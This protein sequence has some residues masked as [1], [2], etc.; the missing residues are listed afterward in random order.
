MMWVLVAPDKF[1]GSLSAGAVAES[2]SAG[3]ELAGIEA[4]QLPLADGGDGSVAAASAAGFTSV[5]I[6]VAGATGPPQR[7][8]IAIQ[9]RTA[10][11]EIANT[12]GL[13]TLRRGAAA[14]L[15]ASSLGLGQ[16]I[17]NAL[18]HQ[19]NTLI[20]ALGGSASTDGGTGM[21]EALGMEF[22]DHTGRPLR[23]SG[24]TLPMIERIDISRSISLSGI[25]IVVASDVTNPLTGSSGAAEIYGPQKGTSNADVRYLDRGLVNLVDTFARCGF[26]RAP[27]I[28]RIPGSG[29]A[30]GVGFAAALLGARIGSGAQYFLDLLDFDTHLRQA[31]LVVTG[32]G[33]IDDQTQSG[34]L[35]SV[36]IARSRPT[37]VIAAAGRCKL[38]QTAWQAAG[39]TAVH[40]LAD[41]TRRCTI[42]DPELTRETLTAIGEHIGCQ[43]AHH[44]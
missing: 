15:D 22:L 10:V 30:G 1:K 9:N 5:P 41:F 20:L 6:T 38:N 40:T 17:K 32:E 26:P 8:H 19:P 35:L 24:R 2:L 29:A 28:A 23:A 21:L 11:I 12:C 37:P 42:D 4:R 43:L 25:D 13:T 3:I 34:K 7:A 31:D 39:F 16:A 36:V 27:E 33:S 18:R 14:P 44:E